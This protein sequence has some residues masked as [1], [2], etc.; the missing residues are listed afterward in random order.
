VEN[1]N[2]GNWLV[3][4]YADNGTVT[5]MQSARRIT[6]SEVQRK[7]QFGLGEKILF[8]LFQLYI[9]GTLECTSYNFEA[10]MTNISSETALKKQRWIVAGSSSSE[11]VLFRG[12][13][14]WGEKFNKYSGFTYPILRL[15]VSVNVLVRNLRIKA[16]L[17]EMPATL[18]C[19]RKEPKGLLCLNTLLAFSSV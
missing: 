18:E 3:A 6:S 17:H 12:I 19:V 16:N 14:E 4:G 7:D 15:T 5:L 1:I 2:K 9:V 11:G 10:Y 8:H 13:W